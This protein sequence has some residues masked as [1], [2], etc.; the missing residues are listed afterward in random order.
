MRVI[1]PLRIG[2]INERLCKLMCYLCT[3]WKPVTVMHLLY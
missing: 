1:V 2:N 3:H